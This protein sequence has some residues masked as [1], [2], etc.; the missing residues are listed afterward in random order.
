MVSASGNYLQCEVNYWSKL[1]IYR[2]AIRL[3]ENCV[4][5]QLPYKPGVPHG[6]SLHPS[7]SGNI[8]NFH[9]TDAPQWGFRLPQLTSVLATKARWWTLLKVKY[10]LHFK[11]Q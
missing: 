9:W 8:Q 2:K 11:L 10:R 5:L 4:L 6:R 7:I 1:K 3:I